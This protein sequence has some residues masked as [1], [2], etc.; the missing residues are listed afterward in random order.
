[1]INSVSSFNPAQN[2]PQLTRNSKLSIFY[3]NDMHGNVDNMAGMIAASDRFDKEHS[4]NKTDTIKLS[5]GD[6][7]SGGDDKRNKLIINLLSRM[8]INA[9]AVG[10]HEFDASIS[11]FY[12]YLNPDTKFLAANA[13]TSNNPEFYKNVQKST[14]IEENGTKYGIIGL[15]PFDLAKTTGNNEQKLEGIRPFNLEQSAE[16]VNEEVKM[17]QKQGIDRIILVS[18][19]GNDK[20]KEIAPKLHGVDI[21]V[22]GHSHTEVKGIKNGENL[23][24]NADNDP[25]LIVQTGENA[26]NVGILNVEFDEKGV[27]KLAEN[28]LVKVSQEKSPVLDYLKD[29][30]MGKSPKI[31]TLEYAD[32]LPN[33]RRKIPCA[34]TSLMCDAMA[35]ESGADIAIINASNARKVPKKGTITERDITESTPLKNTL[36]VKQ[37][38][39]KE[40]VQAIKD[41]IKET[42]SNETG[43]PGILHTSGVGYVADTKGNL[44]EMFYL[45]KQ[46]NKTPID[47]NNP[48]DKTLR[49][50]YDSFLVGGTEYPILAPSAQAHPE[51][52]QS[53]DFDKDKF[54]MDYLKKRPDRENLIIKD[55]GRIQ[56]FDDNGVSLNAVDSYK[57]KEETKINTPVQNN[58]ISNNTVAIQNNITPAPIQ[59]M[60]ITNAIYPSIQTQT[61]IV[62]MP[63]QMYQNVIIPYTY[64]VL[65]QVNSYM[66]AQSY[67]PY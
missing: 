4:D 33:N 29:T 32:P 46:G 48:S 58:P 15:L 25:I 31:A 27:A 39:E 8:G 49:A 13:N 17:L 20:D 62:A 47:I 23:Y 67:R 5:A 19:I 66:A 22:G 40:L 37:I 35:Q 34:W 6:N 9:S 61:P 42:Y 44:R 36:I 55:D 11:S 64:P 54:M 24:N 28:N 18:H 2:K 38:T 12:K 30:M 26:K 16:L 1:M 65:N 51:I 3:V 52:E 57:E 43:E 56:I 53:F 10:N 41:S 63:P 50:C 60:G 14:I 21:I 7:F 59:N 45:D